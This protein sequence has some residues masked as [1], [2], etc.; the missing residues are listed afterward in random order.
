[1]VR[2]KGGKLGGS[3]PSL[4]NLIPALLA[5]RGIC[6]VPSLKGD[7]REGRR[8]KRRLERGWQGDGMDRKKKEKYDVRA[9]F[10]MIILLREKIESEEGPYGS[11]FR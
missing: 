11:Q 5:K 1:M 4:I 2:E 3:E 8:R 6:Q 10:V 7:L 9:V